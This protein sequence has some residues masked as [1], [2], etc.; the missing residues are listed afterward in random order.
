MAVR[1]RKYVTWGALFVALFM[2]R[3]LALAQAQEGDPRTIWRCWYDNDATFAVRCEYQ[4]PAQPS[5]AA[6][7]EIDD[8]EIIGVSRPSRTLN[9][10]KIVR[11]IRENPASLQGQRI[12]IPLYTQPYDMDFVRQLASAVMCGTQPR[13]A[14]V[15]GQEHTASASLSAVP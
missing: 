11:T 13:C 6:R 9:L 5:E 10:P 3:G 4:G 14:V 12:L 7:T 1:I 2:V 8:E 15:F